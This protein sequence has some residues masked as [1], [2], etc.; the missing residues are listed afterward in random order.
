MP[1]Q[2]VAS[3]NR[4]DVFDPGFKLDSDL[5][6][7]EHLG[8]SRKV[9]IYL[10]LSKKYRRQ[11]ACKVLRAKYCIDFSSLEAVVEEGQRLRRL[12]GQN[13]IKG[14]EVKLEPYPRI[15]MEYLP[16]QTLTNTFFQGNYQAFDL[17]D[18]VNVASQVS[19]ALSHIHE[20]GFLHLD[21]KPSNVMYYD[22]KA[23]LF[24]FSVAEEYSPDKP[25]KDNAG[26]VEY[27]APEQTFRKDIGYTTDVFGL[28]VLFYQ[29]LAGNKYPYPVVK[30]P[31]P[32]Y[33]SDDIRRYLD[34]S[35][36]VS[37]PSVFNPAVTEQIDI[38]TLRAIHPD[39]T[40]RY[41]TPAAFKKALLNAH[42]KS[43]LGHVL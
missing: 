8:G 29:L 27:M 19:D 10:C 5:T 2:K 16:G 4:Y 3:R 22:G 35:V 14:Y 43:L 38:V 25:L 37:P 32:G 26:T 24:D 9:D 11:V 40:E 12:G 23:T 30:G 33:K 17:D 34:Y 1:K 21:V 41:S 36:P 18:I 20:K 7:I 42:E 39:M 15:V 13:V 31:L 28:G 6:V